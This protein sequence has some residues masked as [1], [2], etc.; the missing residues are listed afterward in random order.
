[1]SPNP[2]PKDDPGDRI[3]CMFCGLVYVRSD[4]HIPVT[5]MLEPYQCLCGAFYIEGMPDVKE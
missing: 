1:M 2:F 5:Q 3:M 4:M